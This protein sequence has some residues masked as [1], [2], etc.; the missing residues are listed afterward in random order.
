MFNTFK[1]RDIPWHNRKMNDTF[2]LHFEHLIV[3]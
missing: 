3:R 1:V 2:T